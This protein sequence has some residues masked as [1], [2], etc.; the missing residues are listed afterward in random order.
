MLK[1]PKKAFIHN[2]I[3]VCVKI[4]LIRIYGASRTKLTVS[5]LPCECVGGGGLV[6]V[7]VLLRS[8]SGQDWLGMNVLLPQT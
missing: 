5:L 8:R 3:G 1:H 6:C 2:N 7:C 4:A